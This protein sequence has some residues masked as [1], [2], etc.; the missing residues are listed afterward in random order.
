M[1]SKFI[2]CIASRPISRGKNSGPSYPTE[3]AAFPPKRPGQ[4][5]CSNSTV[6]TGR[7][8]TESTGYV[9][10]P[11]MRTGRGFANMLDRKSWQPCAI[12]QSACCAWQEQGTS[13]KDSGAVRGIETEPFGLSALPSPKPRFSHSI[14]TGMDYPTAWRGVSEKCL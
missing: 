9:M 3:S 13:Q 12:W 4:H 6:I 8:K 14:R 10:L 2:F 7:S 5:G 1:P 11:S